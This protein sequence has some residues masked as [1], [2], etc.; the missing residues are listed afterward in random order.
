M[1]NLCL[2]QIERSWHHLGLNADSLKESCFLLVNVGPIF[3]GFKI[4]NV[5][6]KKYLTLIILLKSYLRVLSAMSCK[7]L[8]NITPPPLSLHIKS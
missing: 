5:K 2:L 8:Y 4:R 6:F 7:I 1:N 3:G